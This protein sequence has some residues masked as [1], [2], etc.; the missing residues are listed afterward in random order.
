MT[1]GPIDFIA[2]EFPGNQF[3]GDILHELIDLVEKEIICIIDLV[4]VRKDADG[5]VD[6]LEVQQLDSNALALLD[7]LN[8]EV[9]GILTEA[10]IEDLANQL[11]NDTAAG[12]MLIENLWAIKTMEAMEKANARLVMYDRIPHQVIVEALDDI[13]TIESAE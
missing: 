9:S 7:P 13:S 12:L 8:A 6:V 10:D 11:E 5:T 3:R 2:L 4:V 1:Y